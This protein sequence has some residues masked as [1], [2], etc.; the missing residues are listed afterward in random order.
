MECFRRGTRAGGGKTDPAQGLTERGYTVQRTGLPVH[1]EGDTPCDLPRRPVG[2]KALVRA[3]SEQSARRPNPGGASGG[4]ALKFGRTGG[5]EIEPGSSPPPY[6][7][8]RIVTARC[9]KHGST[10]KAPGF[11]C[12]FATPVAGPEL[13]SIYNLPPHCRVPITKLTS[14]SNNG[15][16]SFWTEY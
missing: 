13:R 7:T 8:F 4:G 15:G 11:Q 14:E 16:Y 6:V 9:M 5:P 1:D 3:W 12:L 2:G 10:K